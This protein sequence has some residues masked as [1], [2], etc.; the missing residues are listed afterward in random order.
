MIFA[1]L[2]CFSQKQT[3]AYSRD[4]EFKEGLFLTINDFINNTPIKKDL[5]VTGLSKYDLD[6]LH[7]VTEQKYIA[8]KDTAGIEQKIETAT[9]WGYCQNRSIYL[10]YNK[11]FNRLNVVGTLCHFTSRIT[12]F[13]GYQDPM[14]AN[15]GINTN[16]DELRQ[17]VLDTQ[18]DN[19]WAFT[20]ATMELL[21]K[22]DELLYTEFMKLKKR[23]KI[24]SIFVY[25]RKYNE[26]HPLY[27][28]ENQ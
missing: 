7:Q 2:A 3:V 28:N 22:N 14:N 1:S 17:F 11:T 6:F 21:L 23:K 4:Y 27:L 19:V 16:Y 9:L 10:N 13:V 26:K 24:D 20:V 25:L 15:Y 5:I 12:S 8:Y 18:T